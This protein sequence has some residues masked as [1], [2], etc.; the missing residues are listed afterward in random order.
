MNE[1]TAEQLRSTLTALEGTLKAA[2]RTMQIYGDP[3]QGPTAELTKTMAAFR[4]LS[5]RLDSTLA[6]PAFRQRTDS[7]TRQPGRR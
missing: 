2:Q 4:Q 5:T 3:D 1:R 6:S 7:L